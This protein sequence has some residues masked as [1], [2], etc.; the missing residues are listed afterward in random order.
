MMETN[1]HDP[2]QLTELS[3]LLA[4]SR[5]MVV[6]CH[7]S[8]DGDALGSSLGLKCIVGALNPEAKVSV[9]TPDSPT[10][11]L[12]F[13]P[14]Y[15]DIVIYSA[16]TSYA[17][18]LIADCDLLLC[19][20]FNQLSRTDRMADSLARCN[21]TKVLI[22]HH[23]D[24]DPFADLTF[25]KPEKAATA[26]LLFE[27]ID[28]CRLRKAVTPDAANCL[29][30]GILTDTGNLS[31]NVGDPALFN[32]VAALI[33]LGA[34]KKYL[35]RRLFEVTTESNL[36][37][38]GFALSQRMEVYHDRHAALIWLTRDD[39]NRFGYKKGDTEGLVNRPMDIPGILYSCYLREE[40]DYIKVSMRSRG[41]F[42]VNVLCSEHFEGGGHLNAAGGEF[43]GT[44]QQAI[45]KFKSLLN[46]N[47]EKYIDRNPVLQAL[48]DQ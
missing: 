6:T 14:G 10:A 27:L 17:D 12:S 25:S 9:I 18:R 4:T 29:L 31:Y 19:L 33:R 41:D 43:H 16:R 35:N 20:D 3:R 40:E 24:P 28:A 36:R 5:K 11:T 1:T 21:A 2:Q 32:V 37:I 13:L 34:D 15:N 30:T 22:D 48:L 46:I 7:F 42:P 44:M 45:D 8:P 26:M 47:Q 39:L 38:Q 23:L